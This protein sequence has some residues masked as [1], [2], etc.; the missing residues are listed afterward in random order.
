ME[1]LK[2]IGA[3]LVMAIGLP[4][5]AAKS[6]P[7]E[8]WQYS[9]GCGHEQG[10]AGVSLVTADSVKKAQ[11]PDLQFFPIDG[12]EHPPKGDY[13]SP[14]NHVVC[15]SM[16]TKRT[17]GYRL[18]LVEEQMQQM[19]EVLKVKLR[20]ISPAPDAMLAQVINYPRLYLSFPKGEYK[21]LEVQDEQGVTKFE[22]KLP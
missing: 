12:K 10:A 20:W 4:A 14:D 5:C 2:T 21:A 17:S 22:L 6:V 13:L 8:V 16:G 15:V 18:E 11:G 1:Y 3:S 19:G 7:V 9:L